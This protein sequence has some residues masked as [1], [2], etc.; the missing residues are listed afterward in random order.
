MLCYVE[1]FSVYTSSWVQYST[2]TL[3]TWLQC[4]D[5]GDHLTPNCYAHLTHDEHQLNDVISN[6][7]R[8]LYASS[9]SPKKNCGFWEVVFMQHWAQF[10]IPGCYLNTKQKKLKRCDPLS[11]STIKNRDIYITWLLIGLFLHVFVLYT[12]Q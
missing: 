11:T 6:G 1:L 4:D 10:V 2:I 9:I 8:F 5:V 7:D 12:W 3:I